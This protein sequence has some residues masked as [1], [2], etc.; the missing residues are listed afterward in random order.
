VTSPTV[1]LNNPLSTPPDTPSSLTGES[2]QQK[3]GKSVGFQDPLVS[4]SSDELNLPTNNTNTNTPKSSKP[5]IMVMVESCSPED[6]LVENNQG[7]GDVK[8]QEK[9]VKVNVEDI[10]NET[11]TDHS[12]NDKDK[13]Y[14]PFA[15]DKSI[16]NPYSQSGGS[17][18]IDTNQCKLALAPNSDLV[19]IQLIF[20]YLSLSVNIILW[21]E[22]SPL[23]NFECVKLFVEN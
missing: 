19:R 18:P 3:S 16:I 17:S 11:E 9:V 5:E 1:Q 8:K 14:T 6:S 12:S 20:K 23:V 2:L 13:E 22:F 10:H 15:S 4:H 21:E 7:G